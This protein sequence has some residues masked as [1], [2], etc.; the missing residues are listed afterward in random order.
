MELWEVAARESIRDLVARYNANGDSGR[1]VEVLELFAPDAVMTIDDVDKRGLD[2]ILT[3]FTGVRDG[4]SLASTPGTTTPGTTTTN[5]VRHM[6]ATHQIDLIDHYTA[7]GR[8]YFQVLTSVGLD[9]WGRYVDE[10]RSIDGRW[11]FATR[12]VTVDGRSPL[13]LFPVDPP[14]ERNTPPER[15]THV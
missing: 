13:S 9:H 2:E 4:L 8:C 15:G 5:Y 12:R 1:F 7:N 14:P 3:I 10:Y 11:R 6:T